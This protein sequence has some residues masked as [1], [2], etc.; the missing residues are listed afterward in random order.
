MEKYRGRV[1]KYIFGDTIRAIYNPTTG[2]VLASVGTG[3]LDYI[4]SNGYLINEASGD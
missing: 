4:F 2:G 3:R 1:D